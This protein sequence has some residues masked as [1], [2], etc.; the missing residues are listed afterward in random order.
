MNSVIAYLPTDLNLISAS[1]SIIADFQK[2]TL[3]SIVAYL[4]TNKSIIASTLENY[5]SVTW[6]LTTSS[7]FG[8]T[9]S[10]FSKDIGI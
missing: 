4:A 2:K 9:V 5:G 7:I 8:L 3:D 6:S 10:S 1:D